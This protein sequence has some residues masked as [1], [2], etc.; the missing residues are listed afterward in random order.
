MFIDLFNHLYL[1][2]LLRLLQETSSQSKK[3]GVTT[4][5]KTNGIRPKI[6]EF[7]ETNLTLQ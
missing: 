7:S 4:G 3:K 6:K 5:K 2:D 1:F